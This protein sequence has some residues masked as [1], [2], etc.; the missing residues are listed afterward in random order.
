MGSPSDHQGRPGCLPALIPDGTFVA[1]DEADQIAGMCRIEIQGGR[2]GATIG[3]IDGPGLV[4]RHQENRPLRISLLETAMRWL[5]DHGYTVMDL[6]SWGDDVETIQLYEAHG[7]RV[8]RRALAF[9][10]EV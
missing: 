7:F 9:R 6:E 10:R 2:G 8:I 1:S 3:S 4:P 5:Q